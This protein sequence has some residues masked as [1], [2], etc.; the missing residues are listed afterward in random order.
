MLCVIIFGKDR[1]ELTEGACILMQEQH[2]QYREALEFRNLK[3]KPYWDNHFWSRG[4]CIDTVGL[5][6]EMIRKHV[7][8]QDRQEG[9]QEQQRRL[10]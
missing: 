1:G 4:Y 2:L 7:K 10:F 5:D 8:Y 3:N 6:I 9:R